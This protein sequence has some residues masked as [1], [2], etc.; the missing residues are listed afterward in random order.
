MKKRRD[1]VQTLT[2]QEFINLLV[3][4]P[5]VFGFVTLGIIIIWK[6]TSNPSEI[7]PHLDVILLAF[8]IFSNPVSIIIGAICQKMLHEHQEKVRNNL[9]NVKSTNN[10]EANA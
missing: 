6:V 2:G 9:N 8:A 3:I 10:N 7:A 4:L 1:E 5:I